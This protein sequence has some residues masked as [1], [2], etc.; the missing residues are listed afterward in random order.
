MA[1]PLNNFK[2][3]TSISDQA[4]VNRLLVGAKNFI[5]LGSQFDQMLELVINNSD[6][7][8]AALLDL[9][10][11]MDLTGEL[12]NDFEKA[13]SKANEVTNNHR[14]DSRPLIITA[15]D[16]TQARVRNGL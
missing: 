11:Q 16:F 12:L 4:R 10:A 14:P 15:G 5:K 3:A 8:K 9:I 1:N 6:G 13:V 2:P 7:G